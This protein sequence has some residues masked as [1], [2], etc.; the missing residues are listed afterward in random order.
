[1]SL[2][3]SVWWLEGARSEWVEELI[4]IWLIVGEL[5]NYRMFIKL[6]YSD[7]R[8]LD[9]PCDDCRDLDLC[10]RGGLGWRVSCGTLNICWIGAI[11]TVRW[12]RARSLFVM[13]NELKNSYDLLS[14]C[15]LSSECFVWV[16]VTLWKVNLVDLW[17]GREFG[18]C[19]WWW[20]DWVEELIW[21]IVVELRNCWMFVELM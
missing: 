17:D 9:E 6:M 14:L 19:S 5:R 7:G 11:F 18:L 15:V 8:S 10:F 20:C 21:L 3:E 13:E 12:T 2:N 16:D 4:F 1:M